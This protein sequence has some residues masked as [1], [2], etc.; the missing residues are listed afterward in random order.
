[1]SIRRGA[2][3]QQT[4]DSMLAEAVS[5]ANV[6]DPLGEGNGYTTTNVDNPLH[7]DV[8]V[9]IRASLNDLW[10]ARYALLHVVLC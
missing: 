8:V 2:A 1:M 3:P 4:V 7:R 9:S 5:A 6:H 10:C